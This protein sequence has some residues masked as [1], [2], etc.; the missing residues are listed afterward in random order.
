MRESNYINKLP[1]NR[2]CSPYVINI[3]FIFVFS[4]SVSL[5]QHAKEVKTN[6]SQSEGLSLRD[7]LS[8][9][10]WRMGL[11]CSGKTLPSSPSPS[12][13]GYLVATWILGWYLI[14]TRYRKGDYGDGGGDDGRPFP[15]HPSPILHAPR[16]NISRKDKPS[17]RCVRRLLSR[18]CPTWSRIGPE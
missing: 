5:V 13:F 16:D 18:I 14:G 7:M 9:G 15:E 8:L 10:A 3:T 11:G 6:T 2:T 17:L 4:P 12:P 1:I